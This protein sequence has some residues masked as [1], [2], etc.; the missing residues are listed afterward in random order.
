MLEFL[1]DTRVALMGVAEE[2]ED[3]NEIEPW[4]EGDEEGSDEDGEEGGPG[5]P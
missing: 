2:E 3:L 1:E 4:P 5:P